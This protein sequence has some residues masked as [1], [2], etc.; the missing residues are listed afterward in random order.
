M[1][2]NQSGEKVLL[3]QASFLDRANIKRAKLI[4]D[5]KK[6]AVKKEILFYFGLIW[7]MK[8]AYFPL[9]RAIRTNFVNWECQKSSSME[10]FK[11]C[12]LYILFI[13]SRLGYL[14]D[15]ARYLHI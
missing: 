12:V 3:L 11:I 5:E 4:R 14:F 15:L 8:R 1:S 7:I 6:K 9:E 13:I 10:A 2:S